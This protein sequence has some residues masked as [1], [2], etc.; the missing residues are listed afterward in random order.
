MGRA[1]KWSDGILRFWGK[2]A[3]LQVSNPKALK[4][5]MTIFMIAAWCGFSAVLANIF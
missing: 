2:F 3:Y 1:Q 5:S 4:I